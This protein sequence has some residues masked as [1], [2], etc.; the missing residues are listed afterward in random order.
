M[1]IACHQLTGVSYKQFSV[2]LRS[3]H[4]YV[5]KHVLFEKLT[6]AVVLN[7]KKCHL[8][9]IDNCHVIT[10]HIQYTSLGLILTWTRINVF[11]YMAC[12]IIHVKEEHFNM[13]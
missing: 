7:F 1:Y 2:S 3:G 10:I 12:C 13:F 9:T 5:Q 8:K 11:R 6:A 4:G